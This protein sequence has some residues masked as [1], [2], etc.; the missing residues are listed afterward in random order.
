VVLVQSPRKYR[1]EK[2]NPRHPQKDHIALV[3]LELSRI[4]AQQ[5]M[6]RKNVGGQPLPK[7]LLNV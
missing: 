1:T 2:T 6:L 5:A 4:P 7:Y 3:R